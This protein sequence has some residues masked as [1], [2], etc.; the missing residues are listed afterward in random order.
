MQHWL[1]NARLLTTQVKDRHLNGNIAHAR[2][3]RMHAREI[4]SLTSDL[5]YIQTCFFELTE[6]YHIHDEMAIINIL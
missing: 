2:A 3:R 5:L 1:R 6:D 4:T